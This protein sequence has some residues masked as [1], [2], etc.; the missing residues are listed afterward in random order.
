MSFSSLSQLPPVPPARLW[1]RWVL[2]GGALLGVLLGAVALSPSRS[3]AEKSPPASRNAPAAP[4]AQKGSAA[5]VPPRSAAPAAPVP[6]Q[7]KSPAPVEPPSAEGVKKSPI[8]ETV[9][10]L[11]VVR[12]AS[13]S[14]V[15]G[16]LSLFERERGGAWKKSLETPL[17]LSLGRRGM[18]WGRGLQETSAA[19][20]GEPTKKEGDGKSPAGV[21]LL[22]KAFGVAEQLPEGAREWPYMQATGQQYCVEDTRSEHYNQLIDATQVEKTGWQKWSPLRRAD[23]LFDWALVVRQNEIEPV[24]GAGSCIFLHVWRGPGQGTAGC[25]SLARESME[26]L[27]KK[28]EPQAA[29]T[30]VQLPTPVYQRWEQEWG[31]PTFSE[32]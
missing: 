19:Q 16:E 2:P 14:A 1:S 20:P 21:F 15:R 24:V 27:L 12:T 29:P 6:P 4:G 10:Q 28:L 26:L 18:A 30:L 7:E 17:P 22:G 25:T 32:E 23:R 9:R 5:P 13:W 8:G 3:A 11:V 31:L